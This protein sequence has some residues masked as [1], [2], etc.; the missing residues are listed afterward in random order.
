MSEQPK[1]V[2]LFGIDP[3]YAE[4]EHRILHKFGGEEVV[5]TCG[6]YFRTDYPSLTT[7]NPSTA[8]AQWAEHF[9]GGGAA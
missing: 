6:A 7:S 2:E 1:W 8:V 4:G 5:C 9:R 3:D